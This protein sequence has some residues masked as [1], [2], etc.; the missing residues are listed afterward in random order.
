MGMYK[1]WGITGMERTKGAQK[2][3]KL[4]DIIYGC[5][6]SWGHMISLSPVRSRGSVH[7]EGGFGGNSLKEPTGGEA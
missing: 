4:G 3:G 2:I 7:G 6:L 5:Y 1:K